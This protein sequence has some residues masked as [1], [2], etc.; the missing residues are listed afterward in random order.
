MPRG[1]ERAV[2][3]SCPMRSKSTLIALLLALL[4][5]CAGADMALRSGGAAP[6]YEEGDPL[7][8][9]DD[10]AAGDDD[11]GTP[12]YGP[13]VY[14]LDPAPGTDDHHYRQPLLVVFNGEATGTSITVLGPD[15]VVPTALRW[16]NQGSR[17]WIHP[18]P[19][20]APDS[21]Y[22]VTIGLGSQNQ[23][24]SF[25]TSRIGLLDEGASLTGSVYALDLA[26][27]S[28]ASPSGLGANTELYAAGSLL[29]A[30]GDVEPSSGV[31]LTLA[32]GTEDGGNWSQDACAVAAP[33]AAE[34]AL[35]LSDALVSGSVNSLSFT[36]GDALVEVEDADVEFDFLPDGAGVSELEID[37][38]VRESSLEALF[39]TDSGCELVE[40]LSEA[41]CAP[42]PS[43]DG[44]C[45]EVSLGGIHGARVDVE[46]SPVS[47]EQTDSCPEGPTAYLGCSS[48]PAGA[49]LW[50]VLL[51]LVGLLGRRRLAPQGRPA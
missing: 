47:P 27:L 2:L 29:L 3:I 17:V 38:W 9:D 19:R 18:E 49:S 44:L 11:D 15:G 23:S 8:D 28:L 48:S 50:A 26:G 14:N 43:E 45:V 46:L 16:G 36:V 37:G 22:T 4:T 35:E 25:S 33:V 7:G 6:D 31:P 32:L 41:V 24:Y 1:R 21:E 13:E 51:A 42:C 30:V 10:D 12:N 20:L 34:E 5:G 40:G 39:D